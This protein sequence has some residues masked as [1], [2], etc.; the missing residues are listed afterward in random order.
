MYAGKI[1]EDALV[2]DLFYHPKHPYTQ[3]LLQATAKI[4]LPKDTPLTPI[5]GQPPYL[6]TKPTFCSFA[7]RCD[8]AMKI[9]IKQQPPQVELSKDHRY[10]CWLNQGSA[11]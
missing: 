2:E 4:N 6:K 8:H 10:C 3:K 7:S 9:C 5:E 1:V 11:L